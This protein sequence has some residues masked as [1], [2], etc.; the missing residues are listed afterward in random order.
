MTK[1]EAAAAL[2]RAGLAVGPVHEAREVVGDEHL[3]Q[4][5]M[6]VEMPRPNEDGPPVLV[7]GNPVKLS[8]VA[9]GP[10]TRVPWV[11]EHTAEV[12]RAEL[13]CSDAELA[14]LYAVGA[15]TRPSVI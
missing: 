7:P 1:R 6:L 13:D 3:A 14:A 11:G 15:I 10:E 12:L 5:N 9:E 8:R 4:R 2:S